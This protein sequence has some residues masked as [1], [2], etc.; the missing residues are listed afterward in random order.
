MGRRILNVVGWLLI[1]GAVAIVGYFSYEVSRIF[2]A[3]TQ[4]MRWRSSS[5]RLGSCSLS[6][7]AWLSAGGHSH[8]EA[9][10]LLTPAG[11]WPV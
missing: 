10:M 3:I 11:G 2:T 9:K 7:A 1:A 6:S 5:T 8:V 4:V